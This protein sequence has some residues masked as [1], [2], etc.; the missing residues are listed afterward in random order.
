MRPWIDARKN[1]GAS[2][3]V[4]EN[5]GNPES[6]RGD[7]KSASRPANRG[8]SRR[9]RDDNL[10]ESSADSPNLPPASLLPADVR[11]DAALS[12]WEGGA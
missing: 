11:G 10:T 4:E 12:P 7:N 9:L 6:R 5:T 2:G 1:E 8:P 3:Y